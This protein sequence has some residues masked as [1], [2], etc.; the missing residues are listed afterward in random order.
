MA[1]SNPPVNSTQE[2]SQHPWWFSLISG[3]ALVAVGIAL[4]NMPARSTVFLVQVMGWFFLFEGILS[5]VMIFVDRRSWGWKLFM[6]IVGIIAGA[7]IVQNPIMGSVATLVAIVIV[8]GIQALIFGTV[9]LVAAF[10]GGGIG[11]GILGV[12]SIIVGGL[13]LFNNVLLTSL[14]VPWVY[15]IFAFFGGFVVIW[16]AFKQRSAQKAMAR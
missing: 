13:L 7:W 3:I 4:W 1:A 6:G 15:S 16:G 14:A 2:V 8:L 12:V 9:A 10:Q 5:I 11:T